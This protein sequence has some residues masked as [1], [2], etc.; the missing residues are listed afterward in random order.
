[1]GNSNS[2][3]SNTPIT[4]DNLNI[5]KPAIECLRDDIQTY[6]NCNRLLTIVLN[7][8]NNYVENIA[9]LNMSEL[10]LIEHFNSSELE[11]TNTY[12][13]I[14]YQNLS[15]M[16]YDADKFDSKGDFPSMRSYPP[17]HKHTNITIVHN[18]INGMINNERFH[19]PFEYL[20]LDTNIEW[21]KPTEL[22][23]YMMLYSFVNGNNYIYTDFIKMIQKWIRGVI[24]AFPITSFDKHLL[25]ISNKYLNKELPYITFPKLNT[26]LKDKIYKHETYIKMYG[27]VW[28][29]F[30]IQDNIIR[31]DVMHQFYDKDGKLMKDRTQNTDIKFDWEQYDPKNTLVPSLKKS[32]DLF[33]SS[34]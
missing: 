17:K 27:N 13:T 11:M 14:Q 33:S 31:T 28:I 21:I 5:S 29:Y 25:D 23:N 7:E 19:I 18:F 9:E 15:H 12:F 34:K 8:V 24:D 10:E 4:Y 26:I 3:N 2:I 30:Y 22:N 20:K 16:I 1:M 32:F 6:G